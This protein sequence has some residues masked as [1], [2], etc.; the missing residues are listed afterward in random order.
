MEPIAIL[1]ALLAALYIVGRGPLVVAPEATVEVYRRLFSTRRGTR[2]FGG[3][4]ILLGGSLI[5]TAR[6]AEGNITVLPEFMG[7]LSAAAGVW[8]LVAP[9]NIE[10]LVMGFWDAVTDTA[11]RRTIGVLNVAFG[12]F[13]GWIAFFVL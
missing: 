9:G 3:V 5:F 2:I 4:L 10:R 8:P 12:L 1:T 6:A 7:W 13:L 11:V